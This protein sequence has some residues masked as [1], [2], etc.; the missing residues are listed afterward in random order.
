MVGRSGCLDS[1]RFYSQVVELEGQLLLGFLLETLD[2][3]TQELGFEDALKNAVVLLLVDDEDVV[4]Q[5]AD[6]DGR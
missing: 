3:Q 6:R 4:L 5:G 2:Q 1:A